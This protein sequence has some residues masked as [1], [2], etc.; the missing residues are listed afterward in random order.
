MDR[1]HAANGLISRR[2]NGRR[3]P[4]HSVE[5]LC[6]F[7][8]VEVLKLTLSSRSAAS[9]SRACDSSPRPTLRA[10]ETI[11]RLQFLS[12]VAGGNH[13][14][15]ARGQGR[16]RRAADRRRQIALLPTA[17]ARAA[18]THGRRLAAHR[19]DEGPGGR[20]PGGGRGGDVLE[21]VARR[22]RIASAL[23]RIAQR[24]IP[25]ALRRAGAVDV[26]RLSRRF[27][28]MERQPVRH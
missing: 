26:V 8:R 21:F 18:R 14:R 12:P 11:L 24:R 22:R 17:R 27:E 28:K 5:Q 1:K 15:L 7:W 6:V 2:A 16:L 23:A 3:I 10:A 9:Y 13:P 19:V 25:A 4:H 20:A